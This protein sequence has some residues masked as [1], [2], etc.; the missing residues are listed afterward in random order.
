MFRKISLTILIAAATLLAVSGQLDDVGRDAAEKAFKRALVTFAVA[1]TLNGVISVAQGTEV[2]VEPAGVGV[3]FAP[4]EVLDPVN[5]LIER[6]SA[7]M[8]VATSALGAQNILL[9]ISEWWGVSVLVGLASLVLIAALWIPRAGRWRDWAWRAA[10]VA[11]LIRFA[12]PLVI[13]ATGFFF[14]TFL[15]A[16][17]AAATEALQAASNEIREMSQENVPPTPPD[18]VLGRIGAFIDESLD[19]VNVSDRIENFR[20]RMSSASEHIINLIVVFIMQT[21]IVPI[22]LLWLLIQGFRRLL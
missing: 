17:H 12:V 18:S 14:D 2:A 7:V 9:R 5:D 13:I 15:E 22:A 3:N 11:L 6:F 1:R 19:S 8:L 4:G 20:Q 16:E 10:L 21:I